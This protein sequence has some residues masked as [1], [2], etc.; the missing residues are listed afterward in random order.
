MELL[1]ISFSPFSGPLRDLYWIRD[2]SGQLLRA[3]LHKL[4]NDQTLL[5]SNTTRAVVCVMEV[6]NVQ[7]EVTISI[8]RPGRANSINITDQFNIYLAQKYV[9]KFRFYHMV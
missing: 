4:S 8:G 9:Q 7:P 1:K 6:S 3:P 5:I 2:Y